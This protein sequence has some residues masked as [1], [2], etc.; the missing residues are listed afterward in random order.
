M[1][2]F[3]SHSLHWLSRSSLVFLA[4]VLLAV[5]VTAS[6]PAAETDKKQAKTTGLTQPNQTPA[7]RISEAGSHTSANPRSSDQ[8]FFTVFIELLKVGTPVV[9]MSGIMFGIWQYRQGQNWK[10]MEFASSLVRRVS[11]EPTLSLA[12][13]FIDWKKRKILLPEGYKFLDQDQEDGTST[14]FDHSYSEMSTTFSSEVREIILETGRLEIKESEVTVQ[15]TVYIDSFDRL[16]EYF[17]EVDSFL[18]MHLIHGD[19]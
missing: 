11:Q 7:I 17:Q 19:S 13:L 9:T 18:S 4:T 10:R 6:T 8:S 3:K 16:F 12:T 15:R 14:S 5:P 2:A 1:K